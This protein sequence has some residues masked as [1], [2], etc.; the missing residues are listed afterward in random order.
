MHTINRFS[1]FNRLE[2]WYMNSINSRIERLDVLLCQTWMENHPKLT[3]IPE[4]NIVWQV[5]NTNKLS[6]DAFKKLKQKYKFDSYDF[7]EIN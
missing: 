2:N 1:H 7:E 6:R 3:K 4:F 5:D